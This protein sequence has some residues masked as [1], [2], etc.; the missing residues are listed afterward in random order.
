LG[1]FG[2]LGFVYIFMKE[3]TITKLNNLN[4]KFYNEVGSTIWNQSPAYYWQGWFE[5][6]PIFQ[7]LYKTKSLEDSKNQTINFL[8]IGC[9]NSRF[10]NFLGENLG[11]N[12]LS[13]TSYI[14]VD[15]SV[16]F[17]DQSKILKKERFA[18]FVTKE[19]DIINQLEILDDQKTEFNC[20]VIFGV[21]HHIPSHNL[22][23]S[24]L[25]Q[26]SQLL[27]QD[28]VLIF[29]TWEYADSQRLSKRIINSKST[30]GQIILKELKISSDELESGDNIIDWIKGIESY[31]YSHSFTES[32]V[33][34]L[35]QNTK[36]E[37]LKIFYSDG[38]SSKRNKYY[39]CKVLKHD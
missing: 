36:M 8:D 22:R 20:I 6:L 29:T 14:G 17:L 2:V 27:S 4:K 35:V 24:F 37:I 30:A 13:K 26:V 7:E 19:L 28:G 33:L 9:G 3:S 12:Q 34:G 15:F 25:R 32:E 31:R 1:R 38:R 21:I 11:S 16:N 10:A 5:L 18:N 39:V 23:Q